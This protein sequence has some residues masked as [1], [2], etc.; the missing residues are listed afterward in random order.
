M[1]S[2]KE[3]I[4]RRVHDKSKRKATNLKFNNFEPREYDYDELEK[5][6]LGW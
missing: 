3:R 1:T 6:L 5:R 4:K 2:L